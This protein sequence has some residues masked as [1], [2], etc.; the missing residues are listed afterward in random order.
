MILHHIHSAHAA[1]RRHHGR[2]VIFLRRFSNH[3]FSGEHQRS[4]EAAFSRA[5]RTTFTG[6]I[7]P[8]LIKSPYVSVRALKPQAGFLSFSTRS[9]TMAPSRPALPAIWRIGSSQARLMML[10][11]AFCSSFVSLQFFESAR[12]AQNGGTAARDD[13]FFNGSASRVQCVFHA[14]F[15]F[16]HFDFRRS[17]DVN[18]CN[19][20]DNFARRSW[21]FS[22][23]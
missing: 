1:S 18:D 6:S 2:F 16:L 23:S 15:L 20:T 14:S 4:D 22:L 17:T 7:T 21:S 12:S 10:I 3:G 8:S 11:P 19:A 9:R 5:Q 13:A